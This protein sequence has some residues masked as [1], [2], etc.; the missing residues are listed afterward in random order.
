M[1]RSRRL[2]Y[3]AIVFPTTTVAAGF[4]Q[5]RVK[6]ASRSGTENQKQDVF[7]NLKFRHVGPTVAGGRVAAVVGIPGNPNANY[8]G[9]SAGG[10]F[11]TVDGRV[12]WKAIFTHESTA[13]IGAIGLAGY[14]ALQE[15]AHMYP[16]SRRA[17]CPVGRAAGS[18]L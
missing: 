2:T 3:I 5:A 6:S 11:M 4:A 10:V 14:C 13:S 12:S 8:V 1:V 15:V 9:A 16:W 18:H 7:K 17:L